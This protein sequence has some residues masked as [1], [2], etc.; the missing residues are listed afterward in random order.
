MTRHA[1]LS[2]TLM[3][4]ACAASQPASRIPVEFVIES[5]FDEEA[6]WVLAHLEASADALVHLMDDPQVAPPGRIDVTLQCDPASEGVGGWASPTSIGFIGGS[7]PR[8]PVREWIVTH[9]LV[10]LF[11]AH[12]GGH[13]GFPSDWWSN[14]R[15]PFPAYLAGLV[16]QQV[17]SADAA[18]WLRESS[19]S[20]PDHVMYWEL[21]ERF[22][23]ELFARTLK[24]LRSDDIDLGE[25]EP[26]WPYPNQVR[27][28]YMIAYLSIA[29]G[30][31][32]TEYIV[33][34]GIGREPSDWADV[35]PE[36]PFEEY[37]VNPKEVEDIMSTRARLFG[38][39]T[40]EDA[41]RLFRAGRWQEVSP[42]FGSNASGTCPPAR[43]HPG[44]HAARQGDAPDGA[45]R[46]R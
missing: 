23:F 38:H 22:G 39:D 29:A 36:I 26:P 3:C 43:D 1:L 21:H 7:W 12:Y 11:A 34:H 4:W 31:N 25:I 40:A 37:T 42:L 17:G 10:N 5:G 14:G 13:G 30:E 33:S 41:R 9:E 19:A 46:C 27:S 8:E 28:T 6:A 45:A 44:W 2:L 16:L 32:L 15:S 18:A 20:Q 35:H 24:M